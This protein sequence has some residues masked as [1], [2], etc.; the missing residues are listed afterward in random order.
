MIPDKRLKEQIEQTVNYRL[1]ICDKCPF[2]SD[3]RPNYNSL[4]PDKHCT[5]CG[6][7]LSAKAACLSCSCPQNKWLPVVTKEQENELDNG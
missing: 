4:R 5:D 6:C 1:A 3:N 2:H 7:T